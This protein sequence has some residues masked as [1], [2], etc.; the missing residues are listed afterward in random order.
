MKINNDI[1]MQIFYQP[2]KDS[3]TIVLEV[4]RG[5][6]SIWQPE[7]QN[8]RSLLEKNFKKVNKYN[9]KESFGDG[10]N[11]L[12]RIIL[13]PSSKKETHLH[14]YRS[15]K[16]HLDEILIFCKDENINSKEGI[17]INLKEKCG[18]MHDKNIQELLKL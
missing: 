1:D 6:S 4:V 15:A 7:E 13:Y 16:E 5:H 8:I 12:D 18:G 3:A 11:H 2:N 9:T 10:W 17:G 14:V